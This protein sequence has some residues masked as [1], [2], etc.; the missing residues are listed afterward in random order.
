MK[1]IVVGPGGGAAHSSCARVKPSARARER[2]FIETSELDR[3]DGETFREGKENGSIVTSM[4]CGAANVRHCRV[5]HCNPRLPPCPPRRGKRGNKTETV[6]ARP[7]TRHLL[8]TG[9]AGLYCYFCRYTV[10]LAGAF[11]IKESALGLSRRSMFVP[12]G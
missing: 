3:T 8:T 5:N 4:V 7:R 10:E 1:G 2:C 12:P 11:L 6:G 9:A